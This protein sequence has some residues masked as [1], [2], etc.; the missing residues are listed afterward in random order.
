MAR[1]LKYWQADHIARR[2]AD[3]AFEHLLPTAEEAIRAV[4]NEIYTAC[5]AR[6]GVT[7]PLKP[8]EPFK[9]YTYCTVR[10]S[11]DRLFHLDNDD[12]DTFISYE[13]YV[14]TNMEAEYANIIDQYFTLIKS[15][16]ELLAHIDSVLSDKTIP[17]ILKE[18]PEIREFIEDETG[19]KEA[20]AL[21]KPFSALL[22]KYLPPLALPA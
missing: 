18:W 6:M 21:I 7:E 2:V 1:K 16:N 11:N 17:V 4:S 3:K 13:L 19:L 15:K 20:G 22:E 10:F 9:L 8:N 5:L 14:P 12:K